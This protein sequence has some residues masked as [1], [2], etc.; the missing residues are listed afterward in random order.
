MLLLGSIASVP[1]RILQ[2]T[3]PSWYN[4]STWC[5]LGAGG[6]LLH[7]AALLYLQPWVSQKVLSLDLSGESVVWWQHN[8]LRFRDTPVPAPGLST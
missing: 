3:L 5:I 4:T 6:Y 2:S 7:A 8:F 1:S